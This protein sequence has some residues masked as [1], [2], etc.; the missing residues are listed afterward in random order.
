[1]K[2]KEQTRRYSALGA[3]FYLDEIPETKRF[4]PIKFLNQNEKKRPETISVSFNCQLPPCHRKSFNLK[5]I[6][7]RQI[8]IQESASYLTNVEYLQKDPQRAKKNPQ[9]CVVRKKIQKRDGKRRGKGLQRIRRPEN[10]F[11][12]K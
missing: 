12:K 6:N 9:K 5:T 3:K 11:E 2:K 10:Y 1:M 8:K 7:K 4:G